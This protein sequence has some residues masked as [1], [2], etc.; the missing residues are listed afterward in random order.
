VEG[1]P[2]GD[3]RRDGPRRAPVDLPELEIE[4]FGMARI[5]TRSTAIGF[6]DIAERVSYPVA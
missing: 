3:L 1:G 5:N 4:P 6:M 2:D